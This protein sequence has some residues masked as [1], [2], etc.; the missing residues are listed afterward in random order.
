MDT[1]ISGTGPAGLILISFFA[2]TL[3]PFSSE[4][5]LALAI[6][7]GMDPYLAFACASAGNGAGCIFNYYS[8]KCFTK[9]MLLPLS[10]KK[11]GRFL[12]NMIR[13]YGTSTV[14]LSWL[15][16]IGDPLIVL[17]GVFQL[18]AWHY[19]SIAVG[20]RMLRYIPVIAGLN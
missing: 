7:M 8:G 3:L 15:P 20:L 12:I 2:A 11:K 17:A 13:R 10:K 19:V 6:T 5:S 9:K 1:I 16:V 4:A 18:K 14:L